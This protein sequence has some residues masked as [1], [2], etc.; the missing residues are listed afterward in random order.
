MNYSDKQLEFIK[1][2]RDQGLE[3]SEVADEFNR[4][5]DT[6]KK[7][8]SLRMALSNSEKFKGEPT[9][10]DILFSNL[11]T[12]YTAK[13]LKNK[14]QKENK[15]ILDNHV[16]FEDFIE[17][18]KRIQEKDQIKMAKPVKLAPKKKTNRTIVA[19]MSDTHIGVIIK[20]ATMGGVNNFNPK[21]A[22][23]RFAYYF[24]TLAQYKTHHRKES[25]LVLVLNGDIIAG[26]IHG[27][28]TANILSSANQHRVA[29]NILSQAIAFISQYFGKVSVVCES[30]NHGR[31][32]HKMN[33]GRQ[34]EEKWDSFE[35]ILYL[36]LEQ[37][38][39][40]YK[41]VKFVITPTPYTLMEIQG[42]KVL[43][44]HGDTVLNV[45][46]V[47]K[48]INV[49]SITEQ[50]NS[51]S[52]SVGKIDLVLVGHVH[53]SAYVILDNGT[54]LVI[55]GTLSGTDEFAQSIGILS[56]NPIQQI[57]EMT[58]DEIVG[59]IRFVKVN[60]CDNDNTLD[61]IIEPIKELF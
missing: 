24:K 18:I 58:P 30:G 49:A 35:T 37:R 13:K 42:H 9:N 32:M 29:L 54:H 21:V 44:T 55:N 38:F 7:P 4:K 40:E 33:K 41:N 51:I 6:D 39:C 36:S 59:D 26:V 16:S 14:I 56:N 60:K 22:A 46:Q 47:G 52:A 3:W 2:K 1:T 43:I 27:T 50:V 34:T 31:F 28:D 17:E 25:D 10:D 61:E 53:K 45:G 57:F 12:T 20:E 11:K 48:S 8:N 15:V 19:H 5:F 23:R